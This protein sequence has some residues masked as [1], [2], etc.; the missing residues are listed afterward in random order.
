MTFAALMAIIDAAPHVVQS[1]QVL[2]DALFK[3]GEI[4]DA[5]FAAFDAR[6]REI[7]ATGQHWKKA[8]DRGG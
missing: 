3:R 7:M 4:S 8:A 2:A 5:E 1:A 6:A